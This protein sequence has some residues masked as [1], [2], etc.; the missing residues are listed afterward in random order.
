MREI[1]KKVPGE[2][3][4]TYLLE[5]DGRLRQESA[6]SRRPREQG[7]GCF[8][9]NNALEVRAG[10][11]ANCACDNPDDVAG[12]RTSEEDHLFACGDG[13][14]AGNLENPC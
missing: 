8:P 12:A 4:R 3:A 5:R 7:N 6:V 1:S 14:P 10:G 11:D 9:Q 2:H 13:Q